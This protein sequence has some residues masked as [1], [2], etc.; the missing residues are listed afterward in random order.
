MSDYKLHLSSLF[1]LPFCDAMPNISM[2][3]HLQDLPPLFIM[4]DTFPS[5]RLLVYVPI[6]YNSR[7]HCIWCIPHVALRQ[8]I[9]LSCGYDIFDMTA[10]CNY[11]SS[12]G[13]SCITNLSKVEVCPMTLVFPKAYA[14]FTWSVLV[15]MSTGI[16]LLCQALT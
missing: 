10:I 4:G 16:V 12:T 6:P 9:C 1:R 8:S 11:I 7:E 15:G 2:D 14:I 3:C 5:S 13:K